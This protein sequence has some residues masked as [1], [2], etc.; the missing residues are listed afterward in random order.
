[1]DKEKI[2]V[3]KTIVEILDILTNN[4]K[5]SFGKKISFEDIFE[6]MKDLYSLFQNFEE[7]TQECGE[8][9][10]KRYIPL[11]DLLVQVDTNRNH[12][13]EYAKQLKYA[14]KLGARVS[15]E[16][17]MI[18]REWDEPENEKFFEPRYNIL[19]G[20]IHYLQELECNPN[21]RVLIF[22]AP[23]GYG[24]TY[25][26]KV[27]EAW[28]FGINNEG[29]FL[30]LCSNDDVVKSGSRTVI[31]EIK[32]EQF[33]EVFPQMKWNEDDKDYFLKETDEKWK[34]R[35]CKLPFSYYAK[36]TQANVVGSRAS[37]SI[38]IDD[39][40]PDYKEAMNQA[41]NKYYYNKS[42]TV[43]E[44][45]YVQNKPPKVCITGTL[46][47][48]GDY[49]DQKIQQLKKE[50]KF[51]KHP[52]YP[53]TWISEDK[54]C[55]II[56]VPALDYET[57]KSTC[58]E[59][60]STEE[61]LKEKANMEDYLW[62]TNFQQRPTNPEALIFSYDKLRTYETIPLSDYIGTYAVIDATR[63]SGKDFFAMPIFKKVDNDGK[64]DYYLKDCLFTRTATKDMYNDIVNKII[65]NHIICLVIESNVT[66]ELKK[67]IDELL[68]SKGIDYCEI[69][70]KYNTMQ[71]SA[72]ITN[73]M[74]LIK[75]SLVFPNKAMYGINTDIGKYMENLTLYNSDGSNPN[76]DAPDSAA[77]FCSEI[78]EENSQPQI[79]IPLPDIRQFF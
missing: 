67:A 20:Y 49:I 61:L 68:S 40:Y 28:S 58:P 52:K 4:F 5:Y 35:T 76:D 74:H 51:F 15:L 79:A 59:L 70:E 29:A 75:K 73:E 47:A 21:L 46:W 71:K 23:S 53:Y 63:K 56:Q 60:K 65:E 41:L 9:V 33:G 18:Y 50:H 8:L 43:W 11:L 62:E 45:R 6:M 25:P 64:F 30:S 26:K 3:K 12:Y 14:Y 72:R 54:T 55:V 7:N 24:K 48:S 32:S 17:Y 27:S 36:T 69:I 19:A 22:N 77:M 16:H 31:D 10:I 57:G 44:K 38:H 66:S 78:I 37:K 2:K 42:I 13:Q 39:L 34:L 1:M